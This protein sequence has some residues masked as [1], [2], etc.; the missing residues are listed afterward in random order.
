VPLNWIS[1]KRPD[2]V[3]GLIARGKYLKALEVLQDQLAQDPSSVHL[4]QAVADAMV[5]AGRKQ[6]AVKILLSLS[7][8]FARDGFAAKAIAILK[9]IERFA[10]GRPDVYKKLA[11]DLP[12]KQEQYEKQPQ[13]VANST[14]LAEAGKPVAIPLSSVDRGEHVVFDDYFGRE[15]ESSQQEILASSNGLARLVPKTLT[16]PLFEGFSS[17]ELLLLLRVMRLVTY[18]PGDVVVAEGSPAEGL[19]ILTS[20]KVNAFVRDAV[21][22]LGKVREL[23]DGDFFGEISFLRSKPRTATITAASRCEILILDKS[24]LLEICETH[25]HAREVLERF[26]A[27]RENSTDELNVRRSVRA[28]S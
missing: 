24:T 14:H 20:G 1:G 23:T 16:T 10:P 17:E 7:D 3:H 26:S 9:K 18:E 2:D 5:M 19:F 27:L 25:P 6:D 11:D 15:L 13:S 12:Y 8:D 21:G 4:R 28:I 22:H